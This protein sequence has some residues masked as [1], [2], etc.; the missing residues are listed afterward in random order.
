MLGV[1]FRRWWRFV[2]HFSW[3]DGRACRGDSGCQ[4][5]FHLMT[6]TCQICPSLDDWYASAYILLYVR[7]AGFL[8][9]FPFWCFM[10]IFTTSCWRI[11]KF[12]E[13]L[14]ALKNICGMIQRKETPPFTFARSIWRAEVNVQLS[15]RNHT[16]YIYGT[17]IFYFNQILLRIFS[18]L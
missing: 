15:Q 10:N 4:T 2:K 3:K 16:F 7:S 14:R 17:F 13:R 8:L 18:S 12:F 6:R 5:L 9:F 11:R 1:R